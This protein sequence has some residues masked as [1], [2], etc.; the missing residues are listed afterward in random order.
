MKKNIQLCIDLKT[1]MQDETL[2]TQGRTYRGVL[3]HI[4]DNLFLFEEETKSARKSTRLNPKLFE[5]QYCS[6]VHM[7]NGRYQVH[8]KTLEPS[9]AVDPKKLAFNVYSE[10]LKAFA[11]I[12]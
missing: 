1:I 2:L 6:L 5:G 10:L 7:Q 8:M 11:I 3:S 4:S 12:D 9:A